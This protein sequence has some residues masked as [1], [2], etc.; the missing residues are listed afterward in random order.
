[1]TFNSNTGLP[2]ILFSSAFGVFIGMGSAALAAPAVLDDAGTG[3]VGTED[4]IIGVESI[5]RIG[6]LRNRGCQT[7][8]ALD[9]VPAGERDERSAVGAFHP[10]QFL[11]TVRTFHD[12]TQLFLEVVT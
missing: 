9:A 4:A 8:A 11:M 2:Q 10:G 1:M 7:G 3:P 12:P 6:A 5:F